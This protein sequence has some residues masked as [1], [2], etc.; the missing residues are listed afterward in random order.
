MAN[1]LLSVMGAFAKVDSLRL[2]YWE[3]VVAGVGLSLTF[4]CTDP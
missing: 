1:L 2:S 4:W 3:M